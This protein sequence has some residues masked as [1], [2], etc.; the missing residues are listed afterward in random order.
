MKQDYIRD[1]IK[2]SKFVG[3]FTIVLGSLAA[4]AGLAALIIGAIPGVLMIIAGLKLLNASKPAEELLGIEDSTFVVE[5]LNQLLP[6]TTAYLK[7]LGLY[8]LVSIIMSII[9]VIIW[10]SIIA[11]FSS[12]IEY[13]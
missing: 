13:H 5:K 11:I 4:L 6:Q 1:F 7:Y 10:I 3:I 12:Q 2:W 9:G 8:Y